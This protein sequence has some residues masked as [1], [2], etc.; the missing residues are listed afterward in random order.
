M[1][2]GLWSQKFDEIDKNLAISGVMHRHFNIFSSK[3]IQ[4]Y[5]EMPK[6]EVFGIF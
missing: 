6:M 5:T 1:K 3:I 4:N 2:P